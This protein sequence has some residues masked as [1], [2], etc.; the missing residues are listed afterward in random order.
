[1]T[2]RTKAPNPYAL[3]AFTAVIA[4]VFAMLGGW[5]AA[6][7]QLNNLLLEERLQS[8]RRAY[9]TFVEQ[10]SRG[11][12]PTLSALLNL[13]AM[14]DRVTTDSE[15]QALENQ[16]A[17]VARSVDDLSTY[18]QLSSDLSIV[19]LHGSENVNRIADDLLSVAVMKYDEVD[20]S[21]YP[22]DF[23]EYWNRWKAIQDR[24]VEY[25]WEASVRKE[26]RFSSI[27]AARLYRHLLDVIRQE[28]REVPT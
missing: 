22:E 5:F 17:V 11:N 14:A 15:V 7:Q 3:A 16:F 24:G 18:V 27:I 21:R 28:L 12:S 20:T 6:R 25:G 4:A 8:R 10:V 2:K 1:M 19:R 26:A 9:E 13:G 23:Q